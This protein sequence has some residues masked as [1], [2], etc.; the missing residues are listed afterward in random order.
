MSFNVP[1]YTENNVSFGPGI[2]KVGAAGATP[3]VDVGAITE[4]GITL[5]PRA[6][7]KTIK[8]GNPKIPIYTFIQEVGFDLEFAGIEWNLN[9]LPYAIGAGNTTS[10]GASDTI[11]FGGDPIVKQI[12][13]HVQHEMAVSGHTLDVYVWKAASMQDDLAIKLGADEHQFSRKY[14]ALRSATDWAGGALPKTERLIK[15][16]R[17]K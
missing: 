11:S 4:D 9:T 17:T 5:T 15:M 16:V 10:S 1:S 8:Q 6:A 14:G 12:A 13:V 3:T 7:K 2:L